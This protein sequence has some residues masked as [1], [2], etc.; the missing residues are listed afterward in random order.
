MKQQPEN[1]LEKIGRKDGMTVPDGYFAD[2]ASKMA[3]SLPALEPQQT[4]PFPTKRSTWFKVRPYVYM[5]AMF[6]GIW[7]MLQLFT[8]ITNTGSLTPM[9]EN[10]VIA[11]ALSNDGFVFDYMIDD[12]HYDQWDILDEMT[13]DGSIDEIDFSNFDSSSDYNSDNSAE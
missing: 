9:E 10:P 5:A 3:A 12:A 8:L 13:Q 7:L 11:E 4:K 1:I 2:F 6:A